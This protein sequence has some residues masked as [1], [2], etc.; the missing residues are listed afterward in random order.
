MDIEVA[1][2]MAPGLSEVIVY[3]GGNSDF[4]NLN[5][6]ATDNAARQISC[7][8]TMGFG[9]TLDQVLQQFAAQGQ[10]F[11]Q[12]SGDWGAGGWI[13][14]DPYITAVGGTQLSMSG[15][16]GAWASEVAWNA[17]YDFPSGQFIATGGGISTAYALPAWQQGLA[18]AT[19]RA[20]T[21]WH[22][23]PD[24]A[25]VADNIWI[26]AD[27]GY[28]YTLGGTS[29]SA[30]LW[31]GLVA[32]ANQLAAAHGRPPVGF[33]NPA[34][35]ALGR[36]ANYSACFRDITT[37][38]TSNRVDHTGFPAVAGYDLCTGWGTP[39]GSNL[40]YALALPQLLQIV[41]GTNVIS[42]GIAGGP[43]DPT[44]QD[45][46]LTNVSAVTVDW[47]LGYNAS[48]LDASATNGTL[49]PGTP[50]ATVTLSVN[51]QAG[52]L[53]VGSYPT[54]LWFTN[55]IDGSVQTR[56]FTLAVIGSPVVISGPTNQTVP[57]GGTAIFTIVTATNGLVNYF[58]DRF[59]PP[60]TDDGRISGSTTSTLIISNVSAADAGSY[61]VF[62]FNQVGVGGYACELLTIPSSPTIIQP[63]ANQAVLPGATAAFAVGA[64]GTQP[65]FYQWQS[66]GTNVTSGGTSNVLTL[67]N[68]TQAD[69]GA[70]SV[71]VSNALG[72]ITSTGAV[73][74]VISVTE[75]GVAITTLYS[76]TGGSDGA[77]P[78]GL[79]LATNGV[80]YGTAISAGSSGNGT[81]FRI[82]T[83][84]ILT[85][86]RSFTGGDGANP[87]APLIQA[88]DGNLYGT[89]CFGGLNS[90]GTIFRLS[91]NGPFTVLHQFSPGSEGGRPAAPLT[92][93][94]DGNFYGGT[95][96]GGLNGGGTLFRMAAG[97]AFTTLHS[98][99]G[100]DGAGVAAPPTQGPDSKFYGITARGGAELNTGTIYQMT[101]GGSLTTLLNFHVTNGWGP[102]SKLVLHKDGSLYGSTAL[103]GPDEAG[104]IF[105]VT[106]NGL[107]TIV[108]AF[109][110]LTDGLFP[111]SPLLEGRDG[112]FYGA[113]SLG[114]TYNQGTIFRMGPSGLLTTLVHF[115]GFNGGFPRAGLVQGP[116]GSY[117]G[118]TIN[119]GAYNAGTIFRLT[120]P[121]PTLNIALSG[122]DLVL[123]WPSWA[124]DLVL[125][126][127][128]DL[129]MGTWSQVT[130]APVIVNQQIQ[131]VI[132]P[133]PAV[134][135]FYRLSH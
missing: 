81:I 77:N 87:K 59:G 73:L 78:N 30:P 116:D 127:S 21:I 4:D 65:L 64:V 13:A 7:S 83:N 10:S 98:F 133:A 95:G 37:G 23:V 69:A 104:T 9:P 35:Y 67:R 125:L 63:P 66:H 38:D 46:S 75:P 110:G 72:S 11:L 108:H 48:W 100:S 33:I 93:A 88:I 41:P 80:L 103:G 51:T 53:P 50:A 22:N 124:T 54:T 45:Y 2:A 31:A 112:Y 32:L 70:Y 25:M 43:F 119:G 57:D 130:N 6:I 18:T 74:T 47:T 92:Q 84:G 42:S 28:S 132:T 115:D 94:S 102:R 109:H 113:T 17:G 91:L 114:G 39:A 86:L 122:A 99:N 89:T 90:A 19:N 129:T 26:F 61:R 105:R 71:I 29:A 128:S 126:Q 44:T 15:S 76:F 131:V 3:E 55:L 120:V 97:G 101:L 60:L 12:A 27:D 8:W 118:T 107:L 62:A 121:A 96:S 79:V 40:L 135:M 34:V 82:T 24:V 85:T 36:S 123:S 20:S 5:R 111:R 134:N 16:G 106:T 68:V 52:S 14:D 49:T 117:Y 56:L 58:W 1:I